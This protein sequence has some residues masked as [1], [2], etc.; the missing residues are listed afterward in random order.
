[1]TEVGIGTKNVVYKGS[2][3]STRKKKDLIFNYILINT[4]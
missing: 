3:H 1:M 2:Y 4:L